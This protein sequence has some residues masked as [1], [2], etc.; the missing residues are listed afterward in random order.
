MLPQ[1]LLANLIF[2]I[3]KARFMKNHAL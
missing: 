3:K 1:I 2:I